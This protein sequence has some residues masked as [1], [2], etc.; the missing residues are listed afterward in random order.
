LTVSKLLDIAMA[1]TAFIAAIF[2]FLSA[3]RKLPPLVTYWGSAPAADPFFT[4]IRFS[5]VMNRWAAF[6]SGLSALRA[7]ARAGQR[8]RK[9]C[10]RVLN[11]NG[12]AIYSLRRS[13]VS[14]SAALFDPCA[15]ATSAALQIFFKPFP[16]T[17]KRPTMDG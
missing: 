15:P 16:T 4:A 3:H 6:F 10:A 13:S 8:Q 1:A 9:L 14:T 17:R 12:H 2:W 5:A 7:F 11:S